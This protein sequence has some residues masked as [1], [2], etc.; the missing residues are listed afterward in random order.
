MLTFCGTFDWHAITEVDI[1]SI[2]LFSAA[3]FI[4]RKW[5]MNPILLMSLTG[6]AGY[7]IYG[8]S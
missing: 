1:P 7:F 8:L 3:L 4:L 2:I 6:L 5:K